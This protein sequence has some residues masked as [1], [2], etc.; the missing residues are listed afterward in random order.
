MATYQV[1]LSRIF[2][3]DVDARSEFEAR[4]VAECFLGFHDSSNESDLEEFGFRIR[5]INMVQ[6]EVFEVGLLADNEDA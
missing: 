3:V 2:I 4:R 5:E 6:N 1:V